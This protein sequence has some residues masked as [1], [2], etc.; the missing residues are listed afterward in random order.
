MRTTEDFNLYYATPDPWHVARS[1]FRDRVLRR[2][3]K[4]FIRDRFV[5]ELGCGE[6]HLPRPFLVGH[7]R[8]SVWT[9][10]MWRLPAPNLWNCQMPDLRTPTSCRFHTRA[11]R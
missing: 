5:L 8:W 7:D 6:G 9:S 11:T 10:A 4:Q 3:L 2:C 1:R